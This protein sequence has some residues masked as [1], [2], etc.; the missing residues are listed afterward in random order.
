MSGKFFLDTNILVYSFDRS[1]RAKALRSNSLIEEALQMGRGIISFQVIQEFLNVATKKFN[2]PLKPFEAREYLQKVLKP[3][4]AV[5][6]SILLYSTALTI[7]EEHG[8]SFY[9]SLIV[10]S[11]VHAGCDTLYSEDLSH[12]Q[13]VREVKIINPFI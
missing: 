2:I 8:Y 11:A 5:Q 4:C 9:D 10:A 13:V 1:A 12:Q 6:S 3:L 7:R